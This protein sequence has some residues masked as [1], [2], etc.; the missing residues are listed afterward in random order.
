MPFEPLPQ[1]SPGKLADAVSRLA[2]EM[3]QEVSSDDDRITVNECLEMLTTNPI[4]SA[5]VEAK[6]LLGLGLWGDYRHEDQGLQDFIQDN[7][8]HMQ[9]SLSLSVA[10]LLSTAPIGWASSEIAYY[11]ESEAPAGL[12]L[13][14][15][16]ILDPRL[17]A[18]RGLRGKIEDVLYRS[19]SG[20]EV[21]IPYETKILHIVNKRHLAFGSPTGVPDCRVAAASYRAWKIVI[22][23]AI[24]AGQRQATPIIV[25]KAP[26]EARVQLLN[27][28]GQPMQDADGNYV[29]IPATQRLAEALENLNSNGGYISVDTQHEIQAL[30][31]QTDGQFFQLLLEYLQRLMLLS[32]MVPETLLQVGRGGLGNEGLAKIH[33]EI[34]MAQ[35]RGLLAQIKDQLI[36]KVVRP[37]IEWNFGPQESYGFFE[38]PEEHAE[39]EL[40]LLKAVT[41]AIAKGTMPATDLA[42]VNRQRQLAGIP[43]VE[44][45]A[46]NI[47][48]RSTRYF[49]DFKEAA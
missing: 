9:G 39:D 45:I 14:S 46:T 37:L 18:F 48:S 1:P 12:R 13:E 20:R 26:A 34:M 30:A 27:P 40:E 11:L 19:P 31:Q 36:E 38:E 4:A 32:F 33:R 22:N 3:L 49:R 7:F 47:M 2:G 15:L 24:L 16:M 42:V 29:T 44:E 10:E 23:E 41:D 28:A 5:A 43:P 21:P 8:E 35:L 6:V 17:Y 25:G